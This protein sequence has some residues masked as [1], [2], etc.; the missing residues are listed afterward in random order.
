MLSTKSIKV[1]EN[2]KYPL[3]KKDEIF[4]EQAYLFARE[5]HQGQKRYSGEEYI[6]HVVRTSKTLRSLVLMLKH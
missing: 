3:T 1:Y 2:I 5:A 6:D 4:I